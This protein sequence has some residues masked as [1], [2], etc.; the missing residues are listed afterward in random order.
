[1]GDC[2]EKIIIPSAVP[3]VTFLGD[4]GDPP[5]VTGNDT[6]SSTSSNGRPLG[7]YHSATVAV[8][9]NYFVAVNMKFE[10]IKL[11]SLILGR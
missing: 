5:T 2:R 3:F 8:N 10:V 7:T 6:A 4:A 9:A 11:T 1:V